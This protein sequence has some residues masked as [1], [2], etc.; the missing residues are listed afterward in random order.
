M[1]RWVQKK[2]NFKYAIFVSTCI[3]KL[4]FSNTYQQMTFRG[5][6][7]EGWQE[8]YSEILVFEEYMMRRTTDLIQDLISMLEG[9]L[10]KDLKCKEIQNR[11]YKLNVKLEDLC[12]ELDEEEDKIRRYKEA[13]STE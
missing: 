1:L 6:H 7:S 8:Y 5:F 12:E 2:K 9:L 3:E 13:M 4:F 10:R 11:I